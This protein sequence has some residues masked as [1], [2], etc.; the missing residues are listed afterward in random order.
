RQTRGTSRCLSKVGCGLKGA[1][2]EA[3]MAD[4]LQHQLITL[5]QRANAHR[6]T[7]ENHITRL[8]A[9]VAADVLNHRQDRVKHVATIAV[10]TYFT[11]DRQADADIAEVLDCIARYKGRQHT[12]T[13]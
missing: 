4:Q 11:V 10:L 13:V 2:G 1:A 7:S 5:V 12:G 3:A 6:R 8:Q 9:E